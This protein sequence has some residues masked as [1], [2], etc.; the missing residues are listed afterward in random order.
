M[1]DAAVPPVVPDAPEIDPAACKGPCSA[2]YSE[3]GKGRYRIGD[4]HLCSQCE[5]LLRKEI[6]GLDTLAVILRREADGHRTSTG[7]DA[8]IRAHRSAGSRPSQSPVSDL[9][10]EL[11]GVLRG[12]LT[13]KFPVGGRL[14]YYA[15]PLYEL[16]SHLLDKLTAYTADE[17]LAGPLAMSV[18]RWH[19][20]LETAA[21]AGPALIHKPLPCPR[22]QAPGLEQ[23]RGADVVKCRECGRIMSVTEYEKMASDGADAADAARD[24]AAAAAVPRRARKPRAA[25][26][27]LAPLP[28]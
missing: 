7:S 5:S 12:W 13:R 6:A 19:G 17:D 28:A 18:R 26:A 10:N 3:T 2:K 20:R 9:L 23:E 14:G 4:P 21:K 22:C 24:E 15:G 16:T 27:E 11:E 1:A 8:A 25:V